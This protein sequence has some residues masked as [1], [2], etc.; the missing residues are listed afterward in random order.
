MPDKPLVLVIDDETG[1]RESMAIALEKAGLAVRTFDDAR[2]ALEFLDEN[3]ARLAVCDLRMPGMDGIGFLNEVRERKIDLSIML[4][5]AYGSI[6]DAVEAMRVGA[7][8][9][10]TK[11]VDLY[12]LRKRVMNL[13]EKQQLKEEVSTLREMLDKRYGF[14]SIIGRSEPMER[15]FEAMRLVAP[16]RSSVL[17]IGESGT[18]KEL[19]ANPPPRGGPPPQRALPG[20]QLRRHPQRHPGERAVRPRAGGLH[21]R[22]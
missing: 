2:K 6:E 13:I 7:D 3:D 19:V 11:P 5:T 18:G 15:L 20:D 10:L 22:R 8:D 14:E 16:T 9:Y 1:S 4:V 17:I 12:E 21:G